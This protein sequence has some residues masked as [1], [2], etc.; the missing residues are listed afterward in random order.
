MNKLQKAT[1]KGVLIAGE[2][3]KEPKELITLASRTIAGLIEGQGRDALYN[4]LDRLVKDDKI[5]PDI[6]ASAKARYFVPE[7]DYQLKSEKDEAL[8]RY[9]IQLFL[10]VISKKFHDHSDLEAKKIWDIVNHLEEADIITLG[11]VKLIDDRGSM[12]IDT[13]GDEFAELVTKEANLKHK[14]FVSASLK[15]LRNQSLTSKDMIKELNLLT[16]LGRSVA[17]YLEHGKNLYD[18]VQEK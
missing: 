11:A 18:S 2:V 13:V 4:A 15:K 9:K 17:E 3:V 5:E 6:T 1:S 8:L 16:G 10:A 12:M 14:E 7:I